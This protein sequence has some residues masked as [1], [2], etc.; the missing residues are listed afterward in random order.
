ME[1]RETALEQKCGSPV[2]EA[3]ETDGLQRLEYDHHQRAAEIGMAEEFGER[4]FFY[5]DF[6]GGGSASVVA[7][8]EA[9]VVS[10]MRRGEGLRE[11]FFVE[12]GEGFGF[13]CRENGLGFCSA[14]AAG[15]P[16]R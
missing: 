10:F 9:D 8:A 15:E 12:I 5:G 6:G 7:C 1:Q 3:V 11:M 4:D 16:A 13:E 14:A 2:G